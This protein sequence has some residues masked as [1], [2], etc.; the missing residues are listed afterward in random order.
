[1]LEPKNMFVHVW[2]KIKKFTMIFL[3]VAFIALPDK[4]D[5]LLS[6]PQS[7]SLEIEASGSLGVYRGDGHCYPTHPNNTLLSD[8]KTD[9]CSSL[10]KGQD[11]MP[12]IQ[13]HY[14]NKAM[15]LK[16]YAVRNG[17]CDYYCCC[18]PETGKDFDFACCCRLYSFSLLGSNDNNTWKTIHKIEKQSIIYYCEV[19][20][21]DFQMT[22]PFRYIRFRMDQEKPG[23]PKCM[24][25]N[26]IEL[27]GEL[28]DSQFSDFEYQ[29]AENDESVSIIGKVKQY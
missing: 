4:E 12:W 29:D 25:I 19:K 23:C 16:S 13:Y 7:T 27:Y 24:Q 5:A 15:K 20:Q 18:D 14:P 21:F 2:N 3:T 1:M 6:K 11:D 22:E 17:C 9:W 10:A 8:R 26:Q 28:V